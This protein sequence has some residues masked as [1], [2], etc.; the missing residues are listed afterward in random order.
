VISRLVALLALV[1]LLLGGCAGQ[2]QS[3]S[4]ETQTSTWVH[5]TNFSDTLGGLRSDAHK[6]AAVFVPGVTPDQA[7]TI[8]GVML[9]DTE[10]ANSSLPTPDPTLTSLLSAGYEALAA[11]AHHCYRAVGDPVEERAFHRS[12]TQALALLSEA[13]LRA[14][15][16]IGQQIQTGPSRKPS[17]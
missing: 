5:G 17:S 7:H 4:S 2:D 6:A 16:A 12:R 10:R 11:A 9:V 3:G 13:Q 1:A 14:E 15:A 8:C